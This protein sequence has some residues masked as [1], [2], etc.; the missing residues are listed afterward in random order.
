MPRVSRGPYLYLKPERRTPDGKLKEASHWVVRDGRREYRTGSVPSDIAGAEEALATY[1]RRKHEPQREEAPADTIN[2]ADVLRIYDEDK[3]ADIVN[4]AKHDERNIRLTLWWGRKPLSS[5][6]SD[7]CRAYVAWRQAE[8]RKARAAASAKRV[9]MGL[10]PLEDRRMEGGARRDLE[11]LRAAINHHAK[12]GLHDKVVNVWLPP[13]GPARERWLARDEVAHLVMTCWREKMPQ[14]RWRGPNA[15]ETLPIEKYPLRHIA[16][17]I[18]IGVYTG[19]RAAAIAAASPVRVLGR[20]YV[21]LD[22]GIFYRRPEGERE[23]TKRRPPVKLPPEILAHLRRWGRPVDGRVPKAFVEWNG[24]PVKSVKTAFKRAVELAGLGDDV[25]PHTLR[26]T[27]A[28]WQM[29]AGTPPWHA[30]G[31]LGMSETLLERVYGHHHPDHMHLA[32]T[33]MS[34]ARET[35]RRERQKALPH[36]FPTT[37]P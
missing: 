30:A 31:F 2:V 6:N 17:F 13:K 5:V 23:T 25:T 15:G 28:T 29:Q 8:E 21:D 3:R 24:K 22:R 19:T 11:D 26:H 32:V 34:R 9:A 20:G 37:T 10:P 33:A 4:K 36:N 27:A 35:R 1:I 18:L 16:R 14:R 7:S 12:L